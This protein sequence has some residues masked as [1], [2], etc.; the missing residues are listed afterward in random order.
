MADREK[1]R[2]LEELWAQGIP[3]YSFS[4]LETINN[5]LYEA[6]LTYVKDLRDQQEPNVYSSL[7]SAIHDC[8][9][10]I[11]NGNATEED[12]L[13]A[14]QKELDNLDTLGVSFPKGRDG[15]DSIRNGWIADMKDFCETYKAPK[16]RFETEQFFLYKTPAGHYLQGYIDLLRIRKDGTLEIY[17][18][19]TSSMYK[20]ADIKDH[21][22]QLTL[23]AMSQE[24]KGAIVRKVAWIFLKYVDVTYMGRKSGWS[25]KDSEIKRTIERKNLVKDLNSSIR[26]K[27]TRLGMDEMEID[28]AVDEALRTN[29]IPDAIK[30]EYTIK[31]CVVYY[32][33]NGETKT[34]ANKYFDDTIQKWEELLAAE[35][36]DAFMPKSFRKISKTGKSVDD[37]FYDS[38]LCGYRN[39]CPHLAKYQAERFADR[40]PGDDDIF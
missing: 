2:E 3:V 11:M 4:K 39:I 20:G 18:Y 13:P 8:L 40:K 29:Q 30:A 26:E 35:N 22:R 16:G 6:Y 5:C 33:F 21:S 14:L 19:K 36:D 38:A 28:F 32:D 10:A 34:E 9:E 25:K 37:S 17:D 12:L 7:G 27:L 31:P 24:Q 1:Q 15:S 23:Y